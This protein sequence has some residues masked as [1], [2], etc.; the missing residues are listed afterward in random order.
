M[1]YYTNTIASLQMETPR[2]RPRGIVDTW[3]VHLG[4]ERQPA[5]NYRV[6]VALIKHLYPKPL[7]PEKHALR[8]LQES[9]KTG[10]NDDLL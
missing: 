1:F 7:I 6:F 4:I 3:A 9:G 10:V 8:L 2:G 5:G